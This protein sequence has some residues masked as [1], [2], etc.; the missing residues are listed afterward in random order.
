MLPFF[1]IKKQSIQKEAAVRE[2]EDKRVNYEVLNIPCCQNCPNAI[3]VQQ[4]LACNQVIEKGSFVRI[5]PI[6]ICEKHPRHKD[7]QEKYDSLEETTIPPGLR[8]VIISG[9]KKTGKGYCYIVRPRSSFNH[10]HITTKELLS[11]IK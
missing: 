7:D 10:L 5:S 1:E 3:S 9:P 4:G 6:G 2:D 8:V 11:A